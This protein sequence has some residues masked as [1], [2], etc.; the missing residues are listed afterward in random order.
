MLAPALLG[1]GLLVAEL[2]GY[3]A[4]VRMAVADMEAEARS[5]YLE[6]DAESSDM[7]F[8]VRSQGNPG[9]RKSVTAVLPVA[10]GPDRDVVIAPRLVPPPS[11]PYPTYEGWILP[12]AME[13]RRPASDVLPAVPAPTVR[14]AA[15]RAPVEPPAPPVRRTPQQER[16]EGEESCPGEWR[17]TWLWEVCKEHVRQEA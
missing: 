2:T 15:P 9:P 3:E 13:V 17:E 10:A 1:G 6:S 8:D 5:S 7:E 12:V 16:T 14:R 4:A 11:R